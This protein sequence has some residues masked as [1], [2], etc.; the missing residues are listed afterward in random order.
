MFRFFGKG[1]F[2]KS[3]PK[4]TEE[5]QRQEKKKIET[6]K[7]GML[8]R[9]ALALCRKLL[10][11]YGPRLSGSEGCLKT[12]EALEK[13]LGGYC[14]EVHADELMIAS[15]A[16][17]MPWKLAGFVYPLVVLLLWLGLP[18][19]GTVLY[20][21]FLLY[22]LREIYWYRPLFE[23]KQKKTPAR[24]IW[25]VIEPQGEA[26][27]TLIFGAHH[28][29]ARL[30]RFSKEDRKVYVHNVVIPF[31]ALGLLAPVSLMQ[32]CGE[33]VSGKFLPNVP[34]VAMLLPLLVLSAGIPLVWRLRH[35]FGD[36]GAPGAGDNLLSCCLLVQLARYYDWKKRCGHPLR[37]TRLVFASFDGEE[38]G[39]RGSRSFFST[40]HLEGEVKMLNFDCLYHAKA[41][42]FLSE[43]VNGSQALDAAL[44][45]SLVALSKQMGYPAGMGSIPLL[46]GGTDAASAFRAGIPS[47]TMSAAFWN[48]RQGG[49]VAH[50][51][52]DV[53]D[54]I[55]EK[56][57]EQAISIAIKW[58]D[59]HEACPKEEGQP[60]Q[61]EK[62]ETGLHFKRLF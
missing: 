53:P 26:T 44:A 39:L 12:A 5:D 59:Q 24:N 62:K 18:L 28:D 51:R 6:L 52:D 14:P 16:G 31:G 54:A 55:E 38:C 41:L 47:T 2:R 15:E 29:S 45:S 27:H 35:V 25:S 56:A 21:G 58:V 23:E 22:A 50:S 57:V 3:V 11:A 60:K 49:D 10:D 33:L 8:A 7:A 40:H 1:L 42:T 13:E 34:S 37:H 19:F 43:D 61:E 17:V 36:E 32:L 20:G 46:G 4:L 30:W 48:A 9:E